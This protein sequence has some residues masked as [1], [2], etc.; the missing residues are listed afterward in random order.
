MQF[1]QY[2]HSVLPVLHQCNCCCYK[3]TEQLLLQCHALYCTLL[4]LRHVC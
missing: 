3:F 2:Q 4:H 1:Q